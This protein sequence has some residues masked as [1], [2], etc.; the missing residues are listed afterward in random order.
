[1]KKKISAIGIFVM[2][3]FKSPP[4]IEFALFSNIAIVEIRCFSRKQVALQYRLN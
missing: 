1:M 3:A 4:V 2:L